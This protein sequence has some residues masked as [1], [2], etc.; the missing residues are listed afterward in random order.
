MLL[1]GGLLLNFL[2][3]VF[4][5]IVHFYNRP[6][7][8]NTSS[9]MCWLHYFDRGGVIFK[10]HG[11]GHRLPTS[12]LIFLSLE[13]FLDILRIQLIFFVCYI[14]AECRKS[15]PLNHFDTIF[16]IYDRPFTIKILYGVDPL[17]PAKP[18]LPWNLLRN[19]FW[20]P[21]TI[22]DDVGI[23]KEKLWAVFVERCWNVLLL[24]QLGVNLTFRV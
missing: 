14:L 1:D 22:V 20:E 12:L 23:G 13:K 2:A 24:R 11:W 21:A 6:I 7:S 9:I 15:T 17:I 16:S 19:S 8:R 5:I 18:T 3:N 4:L 10:A